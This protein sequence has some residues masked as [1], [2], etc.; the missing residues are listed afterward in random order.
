MRN[1][2][3]S[4][5]PSADYV[6]EEDGP[7]IEE[8][9]KIP[10]RHPQYRIDL[11]LPPEPFLG[12]HDAPLVVLSANPG[13]A[14]GD[15]EAYQRVGAADRLAELAK[16]GGGPFRWLAEDVK[17]TPGGKWWRRCLGGLVN[18]GLGFAELADLIL[19]VEF[20]G[21]HASKWAPLPVTLPSQPF[22]FSLVKQAMDW[23]AVIV[24][25]R[26][27]V[28]GAW[29]C[30]VWRRIRTLC[31]PSKCGRLRSDQATSSPKGSSWSQPPYAVP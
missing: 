3:I 19:A 26:P 10:I 15:Y 5:P 22:G 24:V 18:K 12:Y 28:S 21:Y 16:D 6:T 14:P 29:Q 9:N 20:H 23:G 31:V 30:Q 1:P 11:R 4:L 27:T 13:L 17:H 8:W 7:Y 25:T 2:W